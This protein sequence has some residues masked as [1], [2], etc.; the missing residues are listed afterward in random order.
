MI[1]EVFA[2]TD[3]AA[4]VHGRTSGIP[5]GVQGSRSIRMSHAASDSHS[6]DGE[7][8][9]PNSDIETVGGVS[10]VSIDASSSTVVLVPEVMVTILLWAVQCVRQFVGWMRWTSVRF[11]R[12]VP[13]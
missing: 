3:D 4:S 12:A 8:N 11:S 5:S 13:Q 7:E 1:A 6:V 10:N 9:T 2:L